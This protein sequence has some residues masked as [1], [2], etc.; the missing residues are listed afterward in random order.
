MPSVMT[1]YRFVDLADLEE[2]RARLEYEAAAASLTG[3][4]LLA[5]EGIN[6]T[7]AGERQALERFR[8]ALTGR[9]A[10]AGMRFRFS[11]AEAGNPVFHRLK[12]RIKPEIVRLDQ[13][14]V[15]PARRTGEHVDARRFNE[16]LDDPEVL[17]LDTRNHY[18]TA[19]GGF[20]R[21]VAPGT[22]S[23]REL[24]HWVRTHLDPA[25][26]PRIAMFCTG[27]IR[28]EKASAW[29][30][31]QGFETVYQLDGG[32]LDYLESVGQDSR[33]Q[34][35]CFVFDQRVSVN[36]ALTEGSFEQCYGCRRPLSADDVASAH[37]Q[38]GVSCPYCI[39]EHDDERRAGFRERR[40]QEQ[41]ATLRGRRH[42]GA[43]TPLK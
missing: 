42:V 5:G 24:P 14:G 6:A 9:P 43:V 8:D 23:F 13:G 27:G 33:W 35:E 22:R 4:I 15:S 28:C 37:Y 3:T 25:R 39:D 20:P 21:A 18:E 34:G 11:N 7:L 38:A 26:T 32:I 10:F 30:L 16:L 41:L 19:I 29:M 1:F 31:D 17:V 36:D 40:R 2:L 12:V